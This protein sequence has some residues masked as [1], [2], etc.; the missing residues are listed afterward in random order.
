LLHAAADGNVNRTRELLNP[1]RDAEDQ[2]EILYSNSSGQNSLHVAVSHDQQQVARILLGA[3]SG[4]IEVPT[5]NNER[6]TAL[7]LAVLCK[8]PIMVQILV[9]EYH[10]DVDALDGSGDTALHYAA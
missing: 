2:A 4:V 9:R 10:A 6:Y 3:D 1:L 5:F 7:H 8:L